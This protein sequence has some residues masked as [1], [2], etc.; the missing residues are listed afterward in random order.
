[1]KYRKKPVVIEAM[2]YTV[3]NCRALHERVAARTE[4]GKGKPDA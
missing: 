3:E 4:E 1:M 2:H